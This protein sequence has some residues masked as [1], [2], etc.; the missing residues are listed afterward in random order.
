MHKKKKNE[1]FCHQTGRT[2]SKKIIINKQKIRLAHF[3][4]KG[5]STSMFL[6]EEASL[7]GVHI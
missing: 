1:W 3:D 2:N 6:W 5:K 7:G 4:C